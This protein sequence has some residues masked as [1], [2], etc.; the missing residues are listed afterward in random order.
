MNQK[1]LNIL[2]EKRPQSK[3]FPMSREQRAAQFSPFAALKGYDESID[4]EGREVDAKINLSEDE[5]LALN[6]KINYIIN[7]LANIN[8]VKIIYFVPDL[9]KQGGR[10]FIASKKIKKID[11]QNQFLV[12]ENKEKISFKSIYNIEVDKN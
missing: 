3:H 5:M 8:K 7:N 6:Q 4:E 2:Y 10:Y 1:Y 9:K 12:F 11:P